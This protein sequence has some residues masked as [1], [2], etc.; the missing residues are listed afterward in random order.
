MSALR[1]EI[2]RL[3]KLYRIPP[4]EEEVQERVPTDHTVEE[5]IDMFVAALL[6]RERDHIREE[7]R[8]EG[9]LIGEI[10]T[11]QKFLKRPVQTVEEL[12]HKKMPALKE[13]LQV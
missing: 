4:L 12:A 9:K 13:M 6:E 8:Q 2:D 7:G 10:R 1:D 3:A 11:T 5:L